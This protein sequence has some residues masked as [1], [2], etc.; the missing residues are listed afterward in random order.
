MNSN[1]IENALINHKEECG[2]DNICTITTSSESHIQW[3]K[4][5]HK[6]HLFSSIYADFEADNE[7][8]NSTIGN[9]TTNVYKQ[10]QVL[11]GYR[12]ISEL[13]D[14]L[15]KELEDFLKVVLFWISSRLP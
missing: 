4:H 3:N 9:K 6:N 1:T 10:N 11:I 8:D 2:D 14:V 15:K 5:F 7:I 12:I 13:E